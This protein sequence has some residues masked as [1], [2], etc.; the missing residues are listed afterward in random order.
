[1]RRIALQLVLLLLEIDA[2][3][4]NRAHKV[5]HVLRKALEIL[6][7]LRVKRWFAHAAAAANS[8]ESRSAL[9]RNAAVLAATAAQ[10][11]ATAGRPSEETR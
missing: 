3:E 1:M 10:A 2:A 11:A 9:N 8:E 6:H 5:V 7:N 4:D